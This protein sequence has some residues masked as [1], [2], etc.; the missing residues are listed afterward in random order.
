MALAELGDATY[1]SSN[2]VSEENKGNAENKEN[3]RES[4]KEKAEAEENKNET[5]DDT[6]TETNNLITE[7]SSTN[8]NENNS[9][10]T[11]GKASST[12]EYFI[13][14]RLERDKMY[15]Q[16]IESYQKMLDSTTTS[17][18]QKGIARD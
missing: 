4:E 10:E 18:V 16:M 2:V 9:I 3:E 8:T 5:K 14:T 1:V 11:A 6:E 15:S 13:N 12:D 17:E 7:E